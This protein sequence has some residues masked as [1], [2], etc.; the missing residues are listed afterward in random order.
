MKVLFTLFT[1]LIFLPMTA[2]MSVAAQSSASDS[3]GYLSWTSGQ[4]EK[5]GKSTR[6][7]G[8]AGGN[9]DLRVISTNKAINYSLRATLMTPEVIRATARVTQLRDR[10]TDDQT[11]KIVEDAEEAGHLVVMIEINPN[12][13]S[14]VIPLDWRVFLQPKGLAPG[15][16]G[17]IPGIKSPHLRKVPSLSGLYGRNYEY[18]IFWVAFPLVDAKKM[19]LLPAEVAEIQLIV[20]IYA[21]EARISWKMPESIRQKIRTLSTK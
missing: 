15:S 7:Y 21:S 8:K 2:T 14:G 20:G 4:A 10:L 12:E 11:R 18:D 16:N 1:F 3:E 9:F 19:A 6:E 13:G 5:I 17:A